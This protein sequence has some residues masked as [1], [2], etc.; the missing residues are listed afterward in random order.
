MAAFAAALPVDTLL[1]QAQAAAWEG[2]LHPQRAAALLAA[3][4]RQ[5]VP[6]G[7]QVERWASAQATAAL[8]QHAAAPLLSVL[9]LQRELLL[10]RGI[11]PGGAGALA[12]QQ[13]AQQQQS[14]QQAYK[15]WFAATLV[16]PDQHPHLQFLVQQVHGRGKCT[17]VMQPAE[18]ATP[19]MP[20]LLSWGEHL[21]FGVLT[22]ARSLAPLPCAQVLI[23]LVP[24][25]SGGCGW[26]QMQADV[27]AGLLRLAQQPGAAP[28]PL[29]AA[30]AAEEYL[31]AAKQRLK[32]EQAVAAA[33][34][35]GQAAAGG[36]AAP[37][38]NLQKGQALVAAML[39]V[40][41]AA[42]AWQQM[43]LG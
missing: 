37:L 39:R 38:T 12:A 8:A 26:L 42:G 18:L 4:A 9:L 28:L 36:P 40:R 43:W 30:H 41:P 34:E 21:L 7:Q 5:H 11:E 27:L 19:A 32:A 23:P 35:G 1:Q 24:E 3:A 17:N 10:C 29:A 16:A 2:I 6:A 13:G 25:E 22:C 14:A 15:Q 20:K 33:A 31:E